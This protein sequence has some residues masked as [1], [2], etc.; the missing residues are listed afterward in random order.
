MNYCFLS[1]GWG[2]KNA[3]RSGGNLFIFNV[4]FLLTRMYKLFFFFF[5]FFTKIW[6]KK[7]QS[8]L[9][10]PLERSTGNNFSSK[11]GLM[12]RSWGVSQQNVQLHNIVI[13]AKT[14]HN[15]RDV[16]NVQ[17]KTILI[18]HKVVFFSKSE[19]YHR[20]I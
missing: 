5:F 15:V 9:L 19:C 7:F 2:E 13:A 11:G 18:S 1:T 14:F 10:N 16:D 17:R 4:I 20:M 3:S 8:T 6:E 12:C